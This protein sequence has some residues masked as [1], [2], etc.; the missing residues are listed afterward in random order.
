M[1]APPTH[2]GSV[3]FMKTLLDKCQTPNLWHVK[4]EAVDV[5]IMFRAAV[6]RGGV[7]NL[8][9]EALTPAFVSHFRNLVGVGGAN[10]SLTYFGF[11]S[12]GSESFGWCQR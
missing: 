5:Q 3:M 9:S 1:V 4:T 10:W 6:F 2:G 7:V 11:D 8:W 12:W